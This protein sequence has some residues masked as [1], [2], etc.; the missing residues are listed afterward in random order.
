MTINLNAFMSK[1]LVSYRLPEVG[2][3]ALR[4]KYTVIVP[5]NFRFSREEIMERLPY[6]DALLAASLKVDREMIDRGTQLQIIANYGAGV[7]KIDVAYAKEK[8]IV[9]TNTPSAVTEATAELAFGLMHSLLR[10]ITECDRRLRTDADFQWGMMREHIGH[11]LY[12]KTLGIVGLGKIGK[13]L[14]RRALAAR[15]NVVYHNRRPI[16]TKFEQESGAT[17][18]SLF[19]LL[20]Q[21][22]IVSLHTPLTPETHH[23]LDAEHLSIMKSSA[24]LI[25]TARGAVV[26]EQALVEHLKEGMLAGAALDVFEQEPEV[27]Q[28]L[29]NMDNVVLVPHIG[30]ETIES[31]TEMT[32]EAANNLLYFFEKKKALNPV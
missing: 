28:E 22:D 13:A 16:F 18:T 12:G 17:Y 21:S 25:N 23:L 24:F 2:L 4:E 6:C 10:R 7:D 32:Y 27:S 11:S 26:D 3:H 1:I 8:G 20:K 31:R 30:T 9:V 29:L 19:E 15:M 5:E 14:A